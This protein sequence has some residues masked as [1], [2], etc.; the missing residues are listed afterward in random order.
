[1]S[2]LVLALYICVLACLKGEAP[3]EKIASFFVTRYQQQIPFQLRMMLFVINFIVT[4]VLN[5]SYIQP[6]V[7]FLHYALYPVCFVLFFYKNL[8]ISAFEC[9]AYVTYQDYV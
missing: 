6:S 2:Y 4:I 3:L 5:I 8:M 7:V 1:M 9:L